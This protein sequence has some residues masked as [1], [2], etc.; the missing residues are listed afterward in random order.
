MTDVPAH[1]YRTG[2]GLPRAMI[3]AAVGVMLLFANPATAQILPYGQ[4]DEPLPPPTISRMLLR[5]G[6]EPLGRPRFQGDVY[7]VQALSPSG[8]RVR[9]MVDAYNGSIIRSMRIDED[10]GP[11]L[12]RGRDYPDREVD[13]D[14]LDDVPPRASRPQPQFEDETLR[15]GRLQPQPG[16]EP[17]R[18]Q[19]PQPERKAARSETQGRAPVAPAPSRRSAQPAAPATTPAAPAPVVEKPKED[20]PVH[21]KPAATAA[22]PAPSPKEDMPAAAAP[23][24]APLPVEAARPA[25]AKPEAARTAEKTVEDKPAT[26]G[27]SQA[28]RVIEGVTPILPQKQPGEGQAAND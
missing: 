23:A 13:L 9:L 11:V 27:P 7:M 26:A 25:P 22:A 4:E 2:R 20:P 28:V 1:A 18:A 8:A 3:A 10:L 21:D 24:P 6:Y 15:S 17:P 5:R 16:N 12:P 19:R 14:Q